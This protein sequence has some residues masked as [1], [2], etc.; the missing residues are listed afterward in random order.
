MTPDFQWLANVKHEGNLLIFV[1][2]H[3]DTITGN[4]VV[5]GN[6][7]NPQAVSI[8]DVRKFLYFML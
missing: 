1:N 3:S 4:L 7:E 2:T 8:Y 5:A 6:E